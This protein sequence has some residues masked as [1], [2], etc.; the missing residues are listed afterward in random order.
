RTKQT[1]LDGT[2]KDYVG[3]VEA[4]D[5]GLGKILGA[6]SKHGLAENTLVIFTND[7]GGERLSDNGPFFHHKATVWEGGIR[8]PCILRWPGRLPEGKV[9]ALPAITMDLTASALAACQAAPPKGRTLD[10]IDIPPAL[11]G[12]AESRERAFFWR[13]DRPDRKQKA[14]RKG[15]WKY[16]RDGS[17]DL[18]FDLANDP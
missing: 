5:T 8:V 16:V 9:S 11:A 13:I 1:W 12:T 14:V 15:D 6:L 17:I 10:G 18:L 3:M 7:N 2:R 4:I